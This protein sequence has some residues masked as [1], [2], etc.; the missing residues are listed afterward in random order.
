MGNPRA[1]V[2]TE[3]AISFFSP[4]F[5]FFVG[6]AGGLKDELQIGD[7]VAADKVYGYEFGKAADEFRPRPE[8]PWLPHDAVQ[9]AHAVAREGAWHTR[10]APIPHPQP[11]AYVKPIAAGEKVVDSHKS[12]VFRLLRQTYSDAYAVAM[13]DI[14]FTAAAHANASTTFAV[15]RGISDFANEK[16]TAEKVNSQEIAARHAAAFAF[17]MLAG[18]IKAAPGQALNQ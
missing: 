15:V 18:F 12:E 9:R 16:A 3:R 10:I 8:A 1:A 17:E 5:A 14:G 4:Q 7:V 2:E 6:I 13:E 11:Q